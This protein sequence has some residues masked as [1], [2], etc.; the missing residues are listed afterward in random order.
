LPRDRVDRAR[1]VV[2]VE[3]G[4]VD[5]PDGEPHPAARRS[6]PAAPPTV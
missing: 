5:A 2:G 4:A 3:E 6:V 1:V